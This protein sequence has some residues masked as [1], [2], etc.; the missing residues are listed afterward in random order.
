M[1]H[2]PDLS[3]YSYE[4]GDG[5]PLNVGWLGAG[6]AYARGVVDDR[7]V[8]A[9]RMLSATYE[10]QMR[11]VHFCEFCAVDRPT[12]LGGPDLATTVWLGSAEI[13]V[14]GADGTAYAAPNL[15]IHY[16][17]DHLYRPPEEFCRAALEAVGVEADGPLTLSE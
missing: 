13:R 15:V 1:T 7:V 10:N 8:D 2:Y 16:I 12:V 6:R 11:G 17:T 9:L 4:E 14:T 3:P 5:L